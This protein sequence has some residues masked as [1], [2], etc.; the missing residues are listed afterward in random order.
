MSMEELNARLVA[1][2][3]AQR[4]HL[5]H[6]L[7]LMTEAATDFQRQSSESASNLCADLQ[8]QL[9]KTREDLSFEVRKAREAF[10]VEL[11]RARGA[12]EPKQK[13]IATLQR[14]LLLWG[15]P[16]LLSVVL[17][18]T[19]LTV[20]TIRWSISRGTSQALLRLDQPLVE[21]IANLEVQ[22][23]ATKD[24]LV[25]AQNAVAALQ[26]Q[27]SKYLL[28]DRLNIFEEEGGIWAE[29]PG[30]RIPPD[31]RTMNDKAVVQLAVYP[32]NR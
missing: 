17:L 7:A 24:Q 16:A 29:I 6:A 2:T 15:P 8:A 5:E 12:L 18:T 4:N 30:N 10:E 19:A 26:A 22:A 31:V 23:A 21:K 27:N 28:M 14:K 13:Q 3:L 11:V 32:Q 25:L 20:E 1:G 9:Q